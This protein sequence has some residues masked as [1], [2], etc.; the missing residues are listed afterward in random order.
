M[1]RY[2]QHAIANGYKNICA[3][4]GYRTLNPDSSSVL[5]DPAIAGFVH[6]MV[7]YYADGGRTILY[8][9]GA[10]ITSEYIDF[11]GRTR[12]KSPYIPIATLL[13]G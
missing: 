10:R 4:Y 6:Q 13:C 7:K 3:Q 12:G 8:F 11:A 9:K 5:F 1:Y 2:K